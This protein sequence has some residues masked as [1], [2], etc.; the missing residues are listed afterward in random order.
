MVMKSGKAALARGKHKFKLIFF[1]NKYGEG[2]EVECEGPGLD[3]QEI[4]GYLF[5]NNLN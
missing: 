5:Y 1:E 2:L 3:R 4:S